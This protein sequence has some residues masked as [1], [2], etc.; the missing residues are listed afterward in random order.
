MYL[1]CLL[2]TMTIKLTVIEVI[3][4]VNSAVL[5]IKRYPP[6]IIN[7]Q[8]AWI[9][10]ILLVKIICLFFKSSKDLSHPI[11]IILL[12]R[13]FMSEKEFK[14]RFYRTLIKLFYLIKV[15]SNEIFSIVTSL[16]RRI[17][18]SNVFKIKLMIFFKLRSLKS[19]NI[20]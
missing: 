11:L 1:C 18:F 10:I 7:E 14:T 5:S 4:V 19:F 2:S 12:T 8:D 9:S 13:T 3:K 17:L 6:K 16:I 15:V 20:I